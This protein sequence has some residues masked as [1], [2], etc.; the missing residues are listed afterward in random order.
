[1]IRAFHAVSGDIV[2]DADVS[3]RLEEFHLGRTADPLSKKD[4]RQIVLCI[5]ERFRRF[6][7]RLDCFKLLPFADQRE[8]LMKNITLY[9]Q[10]ILAQYFAAKDSAE[11]VTWI[12]GSTEAAPAL[13]GRGK[14]PLPAFNRA[15]EL[16]A[17]TADTLQYEA[18]TKEISSLGL[19]PFHSPL[20][21]V[22]LLLAQAWIHESSLSYDNSDYSIISSNFGI[23][24]VT[25]FYSSGVKYIP[26][27]SKLE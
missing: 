6:A 19:R 24:L 11:Q 13:T 25:E 4:F 16:F 15:V 8:L 20:V 3:R 21:A 17:V 5:A 1:M 10:Y 18:L 26:K 22:L 27:R 7:V 2:V 14:V 12:L 23:N 9:V